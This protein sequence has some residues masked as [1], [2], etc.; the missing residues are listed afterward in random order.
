MGAQTKIVGG[1]DHS[2]PVKL[3]Y[4][5][6]DIE[7]DGLADVVS[8]QPHGMAFVVHKKSAFVEQFLP[9]YFK[10][11]KIASFQRQLNLY[12][13]KRLTIGP[14]KGGYYHPRFIRKNPDLASKIERATVKGTKVRK[15]ATPGTEPNFYVTSSVLNNAPIVST[16]LSQ[17]CN[18]VVKAPRKKR[19]FR[20]LK[21]GLNVSS[22]W[23]VQSNEEHQDLLLDFIACNSE[24]HVPSMSPTIDDLQY[25]QQSSTMDVSNQITPEMLQR[26]E[27][28]LA[29]SLELQ[30]LQREEE[31]RQALSFPSTCNPV[32]NNLNYPTP[33]V[34]YTW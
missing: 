34:Q 28:E 24:R 22:Q 13:F 6:N 14:D 9:L 15:P 8:W 30:R 31:L 10:Q 11:S 17:L 5:L 25:L 12:G 20:E 33:E 29:L 19:N 3:H 2:F 27:W 32:F 16:S 23:S 18:E 7:K 1:Y 21:Q 26:A 4:V